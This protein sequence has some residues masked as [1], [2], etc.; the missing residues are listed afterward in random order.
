MNNGSNNRTHDGI[1]KDPSHQPQQVHQVMISSTFTDLRE[2]RAALIAAIHQHGLHAKVM[3]NDSAG[4]MDVIESSLS[5]VQ[6][7]AAYIGLISFKYGQTPPC[8]D[9]NPNELSIT[10]LEFNEALRL[11][12]PI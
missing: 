11:R 10:E 6:Q 12:R 7:S 5:M 1:A 2:H 8:P 3:E 9:R 4:L